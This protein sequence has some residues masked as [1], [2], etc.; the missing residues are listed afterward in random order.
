MI[1]ATTRLACVLGDPVEHSRSPAMQNAAIREL[2]L[3]C[4]YVAF[5][6]PA[7]GF[8][9]AV[10]GLAALGV[11]GANVTLPHKEAAALL[12]DSLSE[13]AV[14]AGAA[15]TLRFHDGRIDGHLTD[16]LGMLDA[17]RDEGVDPDGR[18]ALV[19]GAGGSARAAAAALLAAGAGPVR[20]LARR[21]E[22]ARALSHALTPVGRVEL[23]STPPPEPLGIV[24]HCTP[25]GGLSELEALPLPADALERM[26]IVCDFAYRAD[27]SSTPLIAASAAR[28]LVAIDGLELLVR[29]G[30]RSFTLFF[31]A[32]APLAAMRAA[33]RERA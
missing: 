31:G 32:P 10:H 23:V 4:V 29:P 16:G 22:A 20:L 12:C 11:T 13:E 14:A 26:D 7:A 24:V 6:V 9:T 15:N 5:R 27:G 8:G 19:V 30:A 21:A 3:D 18:P 17:L 1:R 2:G 28:G 33:A 25:V